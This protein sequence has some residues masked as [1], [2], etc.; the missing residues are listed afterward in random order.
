MY[1]NNRY[2]LSKLARAIIALCITFGA[3]A[4]ADVGVVQPEAAAR[5]YSKTELVEK[6]RAAGR[7]PT[8][9]LLM[10]EEEVDARFRKVIASRRLVGEA[11]LMQIATEVTTRN[12][13]FRQLRDADFQAISRDLGGMPRNEIEANLGA[14]RDLY[15]AKMSY[16]GLVRVAAVVSSRAGEPA[17][18][19][20]PRMGMDGANL[21]EL[22]K[23]VGK[24]YLY[25]DMV[26]ARDE[27]WAF[28]R[29]YGLGGDGGHRNA[30][31]HAIWNI[32]IVKYTG[33]SFH[34]VDEAITWAKKMTDAHEY[35]GPTPADLR[36]RT[37]DLHNNRIGL[38]IVRTHAYSEFRNGLWRVAAPDVTFLKAVV[39]ARAD[40]AV[41]FSQSAELSSLA[42]SLVFFKIPSRLAVHRLYNPAIPDHLYTRTSGEGTTSGW[43]TEANNYV[44]L[45]SGYSISYASLYRCWVG[46]RHYVSLDVMCE[47]NVRAEGEMG[48]VATTQHHGTKPLFRLV[49]PRTR[50]RLT[51]WSTEERDRAISQYGYRFERITGYAWVTRE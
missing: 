24:F 20:S 13:D 44:W 26:R 21:E 15:F 33:W 45:S 8:E 31:Q 38:S 17:S 51:T 14:I 10:S 12:P 30:G 3:T 42:T 16:E 29:E 41:K 47:A 18:R 23:G 11:D 5:V 4:C 1:F 46:G 25:N 9:G 48:R 32:L 27:A 19:V 28:T 6:M 39:R 35:G 22:L 36:H 2:R 34:S 43:R 50:D 49:H 7:V 37:M 40:K